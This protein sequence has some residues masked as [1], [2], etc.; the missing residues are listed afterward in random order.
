LLKVEVYPLEV[1]K[2]RPNWP[3]KG[4]RRLGWLSKKDAAALVDEPELI[5][6]IQ[7]FGDCAL[8]EQY[9]NGS[10]PQVEPGR[11]RG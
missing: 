8:G 5:T 2:Q 7:R 6:L 1:Q 3:E 10:P 9:P 11:R 4:S